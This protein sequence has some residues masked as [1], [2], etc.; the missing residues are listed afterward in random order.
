[1]VPL[2]RHPV[3][4]LMFNLILSQ[5][6]YERSEVRISDAVVSLDFITRGFDVS[7]AQ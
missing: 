4:T 3:F 1:M 5:T 7:S 2:L 6:I